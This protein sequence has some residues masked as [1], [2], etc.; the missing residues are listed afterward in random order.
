MFH[1]SLLLY[2]QLWHLIRLSSLWFSIPASDSPH[3]SLWLFY[4]SLDFP[5]NPLNIG[6][7]LSFSF[8]ALDFGSSVLHDDWLWFSVPSLFFLIFSSSLLSDSSAHESLIRPQNFSFNPLTLFSSS[9]GSS[10]G[11]YRQF[12]DWRRDLAEWFERLTA[13]AEVAKVLG[14]IP[15]ASDTVESEGRQM[16]QCWRKYCTMKNQENPL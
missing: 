14:S 16:N 9:S 3:Y 4:P 6:I 8:L 11:G 5:L 7:S 1:F 10:L 12:S 15:A 13:N 2:S